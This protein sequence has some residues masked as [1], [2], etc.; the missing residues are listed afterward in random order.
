MARSVARARIGASS[1]HSGEMSVTGSRGPDPADG[2][3]RQMSEGQARGSEGTALPTTTVGEV[4]RPPA[5]TVETQA[6]LAAAAYLMK[7]SHDNALVIVSDDDTRRPL[8]IITDAD[9]SQAVAD[10]RDPEQVRISELHI[11]R[12]L[13]TVEPDTPTDA[14]LRRMLDSDAHHLVVVRDGGCVGIVD[15]SDLCRTLLGARQPSGLGDG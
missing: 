2:E 12:R 15:M 1:T 6:H 11:G 5:T 7:R 4:M 8:G 10:G 3:G 9:I 13:A 14:A